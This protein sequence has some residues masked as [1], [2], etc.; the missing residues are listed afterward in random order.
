MPAKGVARLIPGWIRSLIDYHSNAYRFHSTLDTTHPYKATAWSWLALGRPILFTFNQTPDGQSGKST[1]GAA[2][3]VNEVLLIGTPLMWWAFVPVLLWLLWHWAT[4]RDWRAGAVLVAFVAGW[5]VYL[6]YPKRTSFLFYMA[7]LMPFLILGLTLALGTLIG[8]ARV[9]SMRL[10]RYRPNW[11]VLLAALYLGAVVADFAWM[12][13]VYTDVTMT[14]R[15]WQE[16]MWFP[17]WV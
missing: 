4:T 12:W 6:P 3:C 16:H 11:G 5:A 10:L 14:Y 1:C 8:A 15:T 17:S 2:K 13:P 7:P 9:P